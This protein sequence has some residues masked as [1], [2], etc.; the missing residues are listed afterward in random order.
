M[1]LLQQATNSNLALIHKA[2]GDFEQAKEKIGW[3]L[4]SG[5]TYSWLRPLLTVTDISTACVVVIFRVKVSRIT[6]LDGNKFRLLIWLVNEWMKSWSYGRLSVK[7]W[8]YSLLKLVMSWVRFYP[9]I[10]TVKQSFIVSQI[11]DCPVS[12]ACVRQ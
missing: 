8:S 4:S 11:F 12:F 10:I 6:S 9:S 7:P 5:W 2:L 1:F 3:A